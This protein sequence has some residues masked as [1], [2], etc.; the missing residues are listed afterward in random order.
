M[1]TA[2]LLVIGLPILGAVYWSR[3]HRPDR[4][5][6]RVED[7]GSDLVIARAGFLDAVNRHDTR[8]QNRFQKEMLAARTRQL[9]A[10]VG[11]G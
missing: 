3:L 10:E 2:L 5:L 11:R 1:L 9:R 4:E 8:D 7:P 6:E